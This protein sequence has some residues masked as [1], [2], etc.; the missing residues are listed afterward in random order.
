MPSALRHPCY[1]PVLARQTSRHGRKRGRK[2]ATIEVARK[3]AEAIWW[4][5]IRQQPFAPAGAGKKCRRPSNRLLAAAR[6]RESEPRDKIET[7]TAGPARAEHRLAD[8]HNLGCGSIHR[9]EDLS[10]WADAGESV[11]KTLRRDSETAWRRPLS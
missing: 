1:E 4:M 3:L 11:S 10:S 9:A 2:I 5:L 8:K 7:L 6:A